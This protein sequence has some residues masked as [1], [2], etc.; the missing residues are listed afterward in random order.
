MIRPFKYIPD[1]WITSPELEWSDCH[2]FFLS[3]FWTGNQVPYTCLGNYNSSVSQGQNLNG[4]EFKCLV[5][6]EN[7]PSKTRL[8]WNSDPHCNFTL[9]TVSRRVVQL[10]WCNNR[11]RRWGLKQ[12]W[13]KSTIEKARWFKIRYILSTIHKCSLELLLAPKKW[14]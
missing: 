13:E 10:A 9:S 5:T 1:N 6:A 4:P 8:V 3:D 7:D 14:K 11:V 12:K 2:F